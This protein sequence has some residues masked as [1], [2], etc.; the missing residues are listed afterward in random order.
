[1]NGSL[2]IRADAK[3]SVKP[4]I[5]FLL[6]S[7]AE[8]FAAAKFG[9][10]NQTSGLCLSI[11]PLIYANSNYPCKQRHFFYRGGVD[12]TRAAPVEVL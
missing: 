10:V 12:T 4:V 1:M 8:T 5:T 7:E 9:L 6:A 2:T 3:M 11:S